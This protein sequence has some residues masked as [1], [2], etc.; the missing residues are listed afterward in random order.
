MEDCVYTTIT[1]AAGNAAYSF[2]PLL[3]Q[4]NPFEKPMYLS[5]LGSKG[6]VEKLE[7]IKMEI[8]DCCFNSIR[9]VYVTDDPDK[10]FGNSHWIIMMASIAKPKTV[11]ERSYLLKQNVLIFREHAIS[12]NKYARQDAKIIVVSNPTNTLAMVCRKFAPNIKTENITCMNRIEH[13]RAVGKILRA[14]PNAHL[15]LNK[16]TLWGNHS[17]SV[18]TDVSRIELPS[19]YDINTFKKDLIEFVRFRGQ[20]VLR[21][22]GEPSC[23]SAAKAVLDQIQTLLRPSKYGEWTTLGV[24]SKGYYSFPK[25]LF[26]SLPVQVKE[27]SQFEI[28]KDLTIPKELEGL[29]QTSIQELINERHLVEEVLNNSE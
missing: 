18:G 26:C 1:G 23:L 7:A 13:N 28:I 15:D 2:I 25:N 27:N 4:A 20:N 8:E 10:A 21:A 11:L 22:R 19:L 29:F 3:A 14:F 16:L 6:T 5:L 17:E 24:E 12:L 9:G